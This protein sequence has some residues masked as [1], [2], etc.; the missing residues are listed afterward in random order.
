MLSPNNSYVQSDVTSDAHFYSGFINAPI[1]LND[2]STLLTGIRGNSWKVSYSPEQIWP[3]TYYSLGIT[4]GYNHKFNENKSFLFILLPRLNSD[5]RNINS[6][7]LQ[8]GFFTTYSKR[9]SGR[10]LWK[11]GVYFNTEFFGP[12]VVPL[13]GLNWD[14]TPKL[15]ITG[16]LPIYAKI[17]FKTGSNFS[18]GI[19]YLALVSS[20]RLTEEFQDDYTSRYAIEPYGFGEIKFLKKLFFNGKIGYTLGRRY[21]IYAKDDRVDLQLSF[22]K[23]G[24]DRNQLNP[25]IEDNFFIEIGLSFKIDITDDVK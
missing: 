18:L 25:E 9:S 5:Y 22:I 24:D 6:N 1:V 7:A 13:F 2:Q 4:L 21:P 10:F 20:Y 16:D 3:E 8:L 14:V 12:F 19:G 15:N 23:F 17:K 11:L